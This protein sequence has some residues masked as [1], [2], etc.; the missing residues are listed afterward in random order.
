ML[1]PSNPEI[2]TGS[3]GRGLEKDRELTTRASAES[4][5]FINSYLCEIRQEG[6]LQAGKPFRNWSYVREVCLDQN[7]DPTKFLVLMLV[8][9]FEKFLYNFLTVFF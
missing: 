2:S 8:C 9:P 3:K 7:K 6:S 1:C 5:W 4:K